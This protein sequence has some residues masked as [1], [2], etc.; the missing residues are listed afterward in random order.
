MSAKLLLRQRR[1]LRDGIGHLVAWRV[2][3][4]QRHP[5]GVRYRVAFIAAGER[6]PSV[7]Y[8][9]HYPKGHH[10]HIG[11]KESPYDF[12]GIAKLLGD[13]WADVDAWRKNREKRA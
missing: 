4:N 5:E 2:P 9:N 10:K 8:D 3:R 6:T 12:R 7:L 11:D 1:A 13:F